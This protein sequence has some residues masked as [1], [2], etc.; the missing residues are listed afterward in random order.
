MMIHSALELW[1]ARKVD[2]GVIAALISADKAGRRT[3][4]TKRD[5][6]VTTQQRSTDPL[7]WLRRVHR[8]LP[9]HR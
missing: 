4:E 9:F 3:A 1:A 6:P 7:K 5:C 2:E 8:S